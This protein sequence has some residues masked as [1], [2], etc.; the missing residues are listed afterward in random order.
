[1]DE[2]ITEEGED[3][4]EDADGADG[5]AETRDQAPTERGPAAGAGAGA[6]LPSGHPPLALRDLES[7]LEI[8]PPDHLRVSAYMY[9]GPGCARRRG[10]WRLWPWMPLH[11]DGAGC[12]AALRPRG[13][14]AVT[15]SV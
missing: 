15:C 2:T 14:F 12:L 5:D 13:S 7:R 9:I 10:P 6:D 1:M 4:D 8:I 3:E 11:V